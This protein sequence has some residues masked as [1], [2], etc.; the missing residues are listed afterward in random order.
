LWGLRRDEVQGK[1][2]FGLDIGLPVERLRQ[3]ILSTL[4]SPDGSQVA[5]VDATNRRGRPL[6][7]RVTCATVG[8]PAEL[9]RGIILLM[10]EVP[11]HD[12]SANVLE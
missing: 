3:P 12:A 9:G 10:Q 1:H 8:G 11:K 6:R 5:I 7:I 4:H 2:F